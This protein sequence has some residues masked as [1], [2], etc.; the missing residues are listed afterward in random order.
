[1]ELSCRRGAIFEKIGFF[2]VDSVLDLF[3][4][5]FC[6]FGSHFGE[7][8][9]TTNASKTRSKNQSDFGSIWE[10]FWLPIWINFETILAPKIDQKSRSIFDTI[11][12]SSWKSPGGP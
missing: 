10:G 5:D 7:H 9:G 11:L 2:R 12:K 8:F 4:N 1:M 3:F 6:S